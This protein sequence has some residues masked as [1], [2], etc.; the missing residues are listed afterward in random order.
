MCWSPTPAS[1][2]WSLRVHGGDVDAAMPSTRP[3]RRRRDDQ[4]PGALDDQPRRRR[5]RSWAGTPGTVGGAVYGN[6]HFQGRLIGEL[7]AARDARRRADGRRRRSAGAEMEFGYDYSRLHRTRRDRAVA[8]TSRVDRRARGA[9]RGRARVAGV[10][11]ADA[12][13][14]VGERRLHLPESGSGAGSGARRDPAVGRGAGGSR[15]AEGRTRGRRARVD[16][17]TRNFI[18]NDGGATAA[19]IARADRALQ[20]TR[21]ASSSASSCGKRSSISDSM[22][23]EDVRWRLLQS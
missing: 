15:R 22:L 12:A 18:V 20:A 16:R 7:V 8:R 17:R 23:T 9:S 21:S 6:A 10:P 5:P 11:Q 3:R 1:A 13:A 2:G 14:R 19:D 4:R